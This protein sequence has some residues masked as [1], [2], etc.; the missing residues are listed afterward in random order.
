MVFRCLLVLLLR[1]FPLVAVRELIFLFKLMSDLHDPCSES[2]NPQTISNQEL[3]V[4]LPANGAQVSLTEIA[5]QNG[6]AFF[7]P[8]RSSYQACPCAS[9]RSAIPFPACQRKRITM[10]AFYNCF[11]LYTY[12]G[13]AS[14]RRTGGAPTAL[15]SARQ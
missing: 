15:I 9:L 13:S 2:R 5:I 7:L 3:R 1:L 12:V 4:Q 11:S 8:S 14:S 6:S 10:S